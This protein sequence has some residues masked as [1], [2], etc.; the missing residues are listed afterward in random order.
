MENSCCAHST[1]RASAICAR[2]TLASFP[3]G[4]SSRGGV[5]CQTVVVR[6]PSATRLQGALHFSISGHAI[7]LALRHL[8]C[9][10]PSYVL[11]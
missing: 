7:V 6:G 5:V 2:Q 9:L 4:H 3:D 1:L 10:R 11:E 8:S